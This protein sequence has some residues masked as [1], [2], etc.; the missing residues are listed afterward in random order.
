MQNI[1]KKEEQEASV[2]S[3]DIE[4]CKSLFRKEID[5]G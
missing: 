5:L 3:K 4:N 1:F 2:H